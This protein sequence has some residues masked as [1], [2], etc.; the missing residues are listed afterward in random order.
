MNG[1]RGF[2]LIELLVVMAI[3]AVLIGLLLPALNKARA[4]AKNTKDQAQ[5]KQIHQ[6][7]AIFAG[8]YD[9]WFPLPGLID[10]DPDPD[11]GETPGR[12]PEDLS[13]NVTAAMY[14][15]CIQRSFFT[16]SL[17]VAPTEPSANVIVMDN[18]NWDWYDPIGDDQYWDP[19]FTTKLTSVCHTSYAHSPM[20]GPR[21][22]QH[23]RD[24]MDS[25]FATVGTRGVD[26]GSLSESEYYAS[27][28]LKFAGG[29]KEWWGNIAYN[30]NHVE[31]LQT[32]V[33]KGITYQD[34]GENHPDNIFKADTGSND[35]DALEG[36][37]IYLVIY[38]TTGDT[39]QQGIS[40][41][42]WD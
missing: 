23:W 19:N 9:G 26:N 16:P 10:R 27:I 21:K 24:T 42:Q 37:D 18:Y 8:D 12:G 30:D 29:D 20:A 33:P 31:E 22:V 13:A 1:K 39:P 35:D 25:K 38:T 14:S 28:T 36:D 11:L 15:L 41:H 6:A 32:F 17:V 34:Q 4:R 5:I 2:T 40:G 7:W 3:I